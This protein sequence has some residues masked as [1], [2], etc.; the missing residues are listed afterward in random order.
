MYAK[1]RRTSDKRL[2]AWLAFSLGISSDQIC[3]AV[4]EAV[5]FLLQLR[6]V[7]ILR[8]QLCKNI[9]PKNELNRR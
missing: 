9:R 6:L 2:A 5:R 4:T 3:S 1:L 7:V 8:P